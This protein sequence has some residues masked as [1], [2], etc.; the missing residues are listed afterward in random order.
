M[1]SELIIDWTVFESLASEWNNLL[2]NSRANTIF[3]SWEWLKS[4]LD[5][6]GR[7]VRPFVVTVRDD[8]G[9]LIGVAPFYLAEFRLLKLV[10]FR[11]LRIIGDYATGQE[12]SDW[13]THKDHEMMVCTTI[14][15]T[16]LNF[17]DHWDCIW[18]IYVPG[19]TGAFERVVQTC[20]EEGFYCHERPRSFGFLK[21]PTN[22]NQYTNAFSKNMQ[23]QIRRQTKKIFGRDG[24]SVFRCRNLEE[25]PGMLE[26]LFDLHHRRWKQVGEEGSFIKKPTE[27]LFYQKFTPLALEKGWLWLFGLREGEELKAVQIGYVYNDTFHQIQE[28]FDPDYL[29]G[30]G[31]VLRTKVIET[32][33]A[34]EV[35]EYD[36]MGEMSDHKKKWLA[37]ERQG[38]DFFIG[39]RSFKNR[40]LFYKHIWPT[41]KYLRPSLLPQSQ[42]NKAGT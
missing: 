10:P 5:V 32:C 27:A 13:I 23:Q 2:S 36:F 21:L 37:E 28:G 15:R 31:N 1:K 19:W 40:A 14:A 39:H 12:Y 7:S 24:V 25:L 35:R 6:A 30:A 17:R 16:L 9:R 20:R 4:W 22:I 11:T 18:M 38:W 26:A 33:I 29:P 34:E 8:G 41:G 42:S 3:L